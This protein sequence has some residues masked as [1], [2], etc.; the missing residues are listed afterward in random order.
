L[1][2]I[3]EDRQEVDRLIRE[4][5]NLKSENVTVENEQSRLLETISITEREIITAS[6]ELADLR[7]SCSAEDI[8]NLNLRK[9]IEF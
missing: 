5:D 7:H 4:L 6:S 8:A 1:A 2:R 9:E 3:S